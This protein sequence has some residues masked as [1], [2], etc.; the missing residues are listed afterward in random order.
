MN[1]LKLTPNQ[2]QKLTQA[3]SAENATLAQ[4][5]NAKNHLQNAQVHRQSILE[6]VLEAHNVDPK[7][8]DPQG[9]FDI[10]NGLLSIPGVNAS[11]RINKIL[12]VSSNKTNKTVK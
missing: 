12:K 3:I 2:E 8:I 1:K 11:E 9:R 5:N 7:D 4:F 10:S 6:M